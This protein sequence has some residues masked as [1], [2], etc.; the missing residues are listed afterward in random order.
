VGGGGGG[1]LEQAAAID[2]V[3]PDDTERA[4]TAVT[5]R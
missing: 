4:V 3:L 2:G 5:A 1:E